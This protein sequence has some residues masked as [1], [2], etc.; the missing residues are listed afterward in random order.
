MADFLDS[1]TPGFVYA[2]TPTGPMLVDRSVVGPLDTVSGGSHA[3]PATPA[4]TPVAPPG[5]TAA[6]LTAAAL[7]AKRDQVLGP[8]VTTGSSSTTNTQKGISSAVLDPVM[9]GNTARASEAAGAVVKAGDESA[10]RKETMAMADSAQAYGRQQQA[11]ADQVQAEQRAQI[12]RQNELALSLQKDPEVDAGRYVKNMSTGQEIGT[13]ILAALNGAFKGM[14]GQQG[15][16]VLDILHKRISDDIASQKEQ[17]ASGRVRRGNLISYFQN[18]GMRDDAAVKAA[19]A[20][21]W[22]MLDKMA[23]A[24]RERIGAGQDRTA[25]DVLAMQL[26]ERAA[27]KNDELKLT[28]GQDRTTTSST[29]Q[30][31]RIAPQGQGANPESLQKLLA[32]RKAYEESGATPDELKRFDATVGMP[33]ISGESETARSR[34]EGGEKRTEDQGKAAGAMAALV[35]F[36]K[37][38]GLVEGDGGFKANAD[39]K[40]TLN[41]RQKERLKSVIPGSSMKLQ[42]AAEAAVEGFGRIQSGGVIS[43]D[44]A[45]RFK[46]MITGAVTDQ[47]LA[48]RLNNIMRLVKPRLAKQ[49][50]TA[51]SPRAIPFPEV[52]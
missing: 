26:K 25:A 10:D 37:D 3:V 29:T 27:E 47:Q 51:I 35:G 7:M 45:V 12:A 4:A 49:D 30:R 15:N 42:A 22:A 14:V 1:G 21:S 31:A 6:P 46:E 19:E 13:V 39:D 23:A 32:A 18:Q 50:Q 28:L 5:A 34:R 52:Q 2:Q 9:S 36:A 24:E 8:M 33:P 16:D 48:E 17:L 41:A 11:Q 38:A 43:D 20:T 40:S 44:E